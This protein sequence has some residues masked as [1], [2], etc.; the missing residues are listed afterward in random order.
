VA[1]P[2]EQQVNGARHMLHVV[3][4]HNDGA[5]TLTVTLSAGTNL[6][7]AQVLVAKSRVAGEPTCP[8]S[9]NAAASP[10]EEIALI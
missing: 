7:L 9:S 8:T 1:A 4:M 6:N 5:Y 3:A 10:Q 2:I